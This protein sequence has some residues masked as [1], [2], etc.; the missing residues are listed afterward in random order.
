MDDRKKI[1]ELYSQNVSKGDPFSEEFIKRSDNIYNDAL[2][3]RNLAEES[4]AHQIL[5]NTGVKIPDARDSISKKEDFIQRVMGEFYPETNHNLKI[6]KPDGLT[7][8][9]YLDNNIELADNKNIRELLSDAAHEY[10]HGYDDKVLGYYSKKLDPYKT[11]RELKAKGINP[12]ELDPTHLYEMI[13][14]KHH[15]KIAAGIRDGSFG[16]GALKSMM[17]NGTFKAIPIIGPAIGAGLATMAGEA[18]AATS[19]LPILGEAESAG[20]VK[21]TPEYDIEN[22]NLSY[23]AR[24]QALERLRNG[25]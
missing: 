11:F 24:K 21:G 19:G 15:A 22:P 6:V 18:N 14:D 25:K 13:A 9:T 4:L 8:G 12:N 7:R 2:D 16:L 20:P 1:L 17:K 23:E 3:A 10:S 5:K